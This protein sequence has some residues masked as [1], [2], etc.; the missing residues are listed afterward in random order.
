MRGEYS[1]TCCPRY[2]ERE[3][4]E[5][6]KAGLVDRISIHT[7]TI[8]GFLRLNEVGISRF[9]LLDHMD[10]LSTYRYEA[11]EKEWQAIVNRAMP[12]TRIIFR[13]GGLRVDYV[14][15]IL[16]SVQGKKR[17]MG[18]LLTYHQELAEQLHEKD[19]VHTYGSFYIADLITA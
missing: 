17:Q 5:A 7:N 18:D 2:L 8:E 11:L 13:S 14:D 4:F 6:L 15:P 1:P 10:W 19:R 12:D 9:V 3:K 16:I